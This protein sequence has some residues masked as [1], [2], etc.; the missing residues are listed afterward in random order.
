MKPIIGIISRPTLSE[1][2]YNMYAVYEDMA[3]AI[4]KSDGIPIG[5]IPN[6]NI[7]ESIN[8]CDGLIFQGG[9]SFTEFELNYLK[10]AHKNNIPTI[11]ICLGMQL[12]GIY[13][14]GI[15]YNVHNH[16]EKDKRYVHK[17]IINKSS[18]LYKILNKDKIYVNSRHKSAIKNPNIFISAKSMDGVIES[19]EDKT[20]TLFLGL[21]WHPESMFEYDE[22]SKE[23]FK[24]FIN[25]CKK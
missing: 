25:I 14:N 7:E 10:Y 17:I 4:Y 3:N 11:G 20:K 19:I 8:L 1:S 22:S 15:E 12:M 21:E 16:L 2:N 18:I 13:F 9:D 5:I 24:Y 6:D 23:I